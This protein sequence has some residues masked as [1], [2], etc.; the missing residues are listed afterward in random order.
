MK[1]FSFLYILCFLSGCLLWNG[2]SK[3]GINTFDE[4]YAT[5]TVPWNSVDVSTYPGY[6]AATRTFVQSYSFWNNPE[7]EVM[8][9][10][11]P[12][13]LVG[14]VRDYDRAVGYSILTDSSRLLEGSYRVLDA[15]IPAGERYGYM[16]LELPRLSQLDD[17]TCM[18]DIRLNASEHFVAGPEEYS[19]IVFSWDNQLPMLPTGTFYARTYNF[20]IN[21]GQ[22]MNLANYNYYSRN[23]HRAILAALGWPWQAE[24]WPQYNR[25]DP[26]GYMFY[27]TVTTNAYY[28]L[29]QKYL[30]DYEEEHGTPLL[31]DGGLAIN[32]PVRARRF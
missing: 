12:L 8:V 26:D 4:T 5:V 18:M 31:H 21:A 27:N 23:A 9:I 10:H 20:L 2:C 14:D 25:T 30:D 17:T 24:R 6:N 1:R 22:S 15:V 28:N 3:E 32:Q 13:K 29:L 7:E 11:I 19:R 16:A